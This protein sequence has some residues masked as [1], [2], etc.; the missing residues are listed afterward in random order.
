MLQYWHFLAFFISNDFFQLHRPWCYKVRFLQFSMIEKLY[1]RFFLCDFRW[2]VIINGVG[3]SKDYCAI[4]YLTPYSVFHKFIAPSTELCSKM[5]LSR[6]IICNCFSAGTMLS[7]MWF[8]SNLSS[9]LV[10]KKSISCFGY[11]TLASLNYYL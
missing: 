4:I 1:W 11:L 2:F 6:L 8:Y 7:K 9:V 10:W 3:K 5:A